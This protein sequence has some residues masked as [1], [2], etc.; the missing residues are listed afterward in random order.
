M[1]SCKGICGKQ[2]NILYEVSC[3]LN[4][5]RVCEEFGN[6]AAKSMLVHFQPREC[7]INREDMIYK[8]RE[9]STFFH[10]YIAE[11]PYLEA[12][13]RN[14][15][16]DHKHN[17]IFVSVTLTICEMIRWVGKHGITY[18]TWTASGCWQIY[19]ESRQSGTMIA[20]LV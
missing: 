19:R 9:E 11:Q 2:T 12:E 18:F 14:W 7:Y 15:I 20:L 17:G 8:S 10:W 4:M 16:V 3:K 13:L 5:I 1:C 6:T